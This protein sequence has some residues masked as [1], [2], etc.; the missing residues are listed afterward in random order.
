MTIKTMDE[1]MTDELIAATKKAIEELRLNK[2]TPHN[3]AESVKFGI[4]LLEYEDRWRYLLKDNH[5]IS[6]RTKSK[7]FKDYEKF[8]EWRYIEGYTE[9][10]IDKS[11]LTILLA[12][13]DKLTA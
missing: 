2:D 9:F 3:Y 12:E 8:M 1:I 7:E 10:Y 5:L 11:T 13:Y 6:Y 4:G